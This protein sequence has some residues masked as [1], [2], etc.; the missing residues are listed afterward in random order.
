MLLVVGWFSSSPRRRHA[1]DLDNR[2]PS[3]SW[4]GPN[5][6]RMRAA[7][8]PVRDLGQCAEQFE[9]LPSNRRL[10]R[11]RQAAAGMS[12]DVRNHRPSVWPWSAPGRRH[13]DQVAV[14]ALT[15]SGCRSLK[16]VMLALDGTRA[17]RAS[18]TSTDACGTIVTVPTVLRGGGPY[19]K[20]SFPRVR[21]G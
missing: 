4:R 6:Y 7:R 14:R 2:A 17:S 15:F 16:R 10:P 8:V 18:T 5:D 13:L 9:K 20:A 3:S 1:T 19:Q 21:F 12:P 11:Q